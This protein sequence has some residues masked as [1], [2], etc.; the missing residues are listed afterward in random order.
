MLCCRSGCWHWS[1]RNVDSEI[2]VRIGVPTGVGEG[3]GD[4]AMVNAGD[5]D[6]MGTAAVVLKE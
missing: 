6:G 3:V 5:G 1:G 2:V 4:A